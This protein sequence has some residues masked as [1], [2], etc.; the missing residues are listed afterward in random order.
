[1]CFRHFV[2]ELCFHPPPPQILRSKWQYLCRLRGLSSSTRLK[3]WRPWAVCFAL[4]P[5]AVSPL[6]LLSTDHLRSGGGGVA[7]LKVPE[8]TVLFCILPRGA[9]LTPRRST[10]LVCTGPLAWSSTKTVTIR[11]HAWRHRWSKFASTLHYLHTHLS[12]TTL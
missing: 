11:S 4:L 7:I 1:M 12:N 5:A 10:P 3:R 6:S 8:R 9:L 2:N